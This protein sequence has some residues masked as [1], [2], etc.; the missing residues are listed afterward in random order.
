MD[1]TLQGIA[2][3]LDNLG[4]GAEPNGDGVRA[5]GLPADWLPLVAMMTAVPDMVEALELMLARF[6]DMVPCGYPTCEAC[7]AIAKAKAALAKARPR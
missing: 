1:D 4:L 2:N 6:D 7:I 5:Y 3:R